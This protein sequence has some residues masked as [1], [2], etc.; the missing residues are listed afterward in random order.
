MGTSRVCRP[1]D[2]LPPGTVGQWHPVT[3]QWWNARRGGDPKTDQVTGAD[4]ERLGWQPKEKAAHV[5][6]KRGTLETA[7]V[8]SVHKKGGTPKTQV[9]EGKGPKDPGVAAPLDA[10]CCRGNCYYETGGR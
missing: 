7:W 4:S 10:A 9:H 3:G 1:A 8:A 5:P 6:Q 2:Y